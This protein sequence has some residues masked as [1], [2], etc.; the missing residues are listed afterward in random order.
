MLYLL[1]ELYFWGMFGLLLVPSNISDFFGFLLISDFLIQKDN[2]S[3]QL[4]SNAALMLMS[5]EM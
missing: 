2:Q 1:S 5:A 3:S 4:P